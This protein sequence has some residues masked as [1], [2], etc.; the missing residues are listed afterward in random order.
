MSVFFCT[1]KNPIAIEDTTTIS[2]EP[3]YLEL[4]PEKKHQQDADAL[5]LLSAL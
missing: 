2:I 1:L 4:M 3:Y 5:N